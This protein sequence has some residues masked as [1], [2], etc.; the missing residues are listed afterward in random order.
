MPP[1][2]D[3]APEPSVRP[4]RIHPHLLVLAACSGLLFGL[5]APPRGWWWLYWLAF[6]PLLLVARHPLTRTP[7]Q[8]ALY[9]LVGGLGIGLVGFPWIGTMLVQ[10]AGVPVLVGRL[11]LFFFSVW[12]AVPYALWAVLLHVGPKRGPLAY[13]WAPATWVP[14]L[15]YWPVLFPY[16]PVLGLAEVP[17]L[18]QLAEF[19]GA[20]LLEIM[21]M[22]TSL[23]VIGAARQ[24]F[25]WARG[26]S[27]ALAATIPVMAF[28]HGVERMAQLDARAEAAPRWRV[29]VVQPNIP[30]GDVGVE[31]SFARLRGASARA[32][33]RGAEVVVWP[34]AG[35]Y[36]YRLPRP[37]PDDH[38][39]GEA[40]VL[41]GVR[42]PVLFGVGTRDRDARYGYNTFAHVSRAGRIEGSYDKSRLVPIGERIPLVDPAW[43]Q[44]MIPYISHLNAGDGPAVFE[45]ARGDG[46]PVRVGPLICLE[47]ILADY[48]REVAAQPGGVEIFVNAT[49]DAWYGFSAEPW[50]HLALAQIRAV[51]HRVP[52]VRSVSTGVSAVVDHLGRLQAHVPSR[53]VSVRNLDEWPAEI[54]VVDVALPRNTAESPTPYARVGFALPWLCVGVALAIGAA[55]RHEISA[56]FRR[57]RAEGADAEDAEA[58]G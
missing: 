34:E 46:P 25:S 33:A 36:P 51:E 37:L 44:R 6:A 16:T 39:L 54:L 47:D 3:S 29:G 38:R 11:G 49:I 1:E 53:P 57:G 2:P 31:E 14:L 17:E 42:G 19:G 5:G 21:A 20:P 18:V 56:A 23:L 24:P 40:G 27:S 22:A 7:G 30:I 45:V 9:G 15:L 28:T 4:R 58:A 8:A 35:I 32:E 10:F 48:T 50:E 52:L 55:R 12:L 13:A 41:R 43:A 26:A